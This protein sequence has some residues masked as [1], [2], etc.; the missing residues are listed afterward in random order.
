MNPLGTGSTP[1]ATRVVVDPDRR[2]NSPVEG[3][4]FPA[5]WCGQQQVVAADTRYMF[6]P[7]GVWARRPVQFVRRLAESF[8]TSLGVS[9]LAVTGVLMM[10]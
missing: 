6:I 8:V 10:P 1:A 3:A 5:E 4:G 9:L 7:S 2:G